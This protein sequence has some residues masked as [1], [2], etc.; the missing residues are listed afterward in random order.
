MQSPRKGRASHGL[1]GVTGIVK[2]RTRSMRRGQTAGRSKK[3]GLFKS[4]G[5]E[6]IVVSGPPAVYTAPVLQQ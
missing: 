1:N 2:Y 6:K 5:S 3:I 4:E